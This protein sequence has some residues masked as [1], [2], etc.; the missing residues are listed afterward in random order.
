MVIVV[1]Q[2]VV[3]G[4]RVGEGREGGSTTVVP[5]GASTCVEAETNFLL[6]TLRSNP[7]PPLRSQP[8]HCRRARRGM[9]YGSLQL[10]LEVCYYGVLTPGTRAF[11]CARFLASLRAGQRLDSRALRADRIT[12][13]RAWDCVSE[14][15]TTTPSTRD[16]LHNIPHRRLPLA[17]NIIPC[18][19]INEDIKV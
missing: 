11:A 10:A 19:L 4:G 3:V 13:A 6:S 7:T 17:N 1:R 18:D 16:R 9:S 12:S 15:T 8:I 5:V 14:G 2:K